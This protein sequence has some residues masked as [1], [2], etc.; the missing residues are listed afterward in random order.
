MQFSV[1]DEIKE[2]YAYPGMPKDG[3]PNIPT[4]YELMTDDLDLWASFS[5]SEDEVGDGWST[6]ISRRRKYKKNKGMSPKAMPPKASCEGT[7]MTS[8]GLW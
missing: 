6:F 3:N 4:L 2:V 8:Q 1:D 5:E 7:L